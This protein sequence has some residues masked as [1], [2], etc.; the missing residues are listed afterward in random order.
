MTKT[1][2]YIYVR[3]FMKLAVGEAVLV[4]GATDF[5]NRGEELFNPRTM[6]VVLFRGGFCFCE[7][8]RSAGE[9]ICI[10]IFFLSSEMLNGTE[11][12]PRRSHNSNWT[13]AMGVSFLPFSKGF[14]EKL[15]LVSFHYKIKNDII[16]K[17]SLSQAEISPFFFPF[18]L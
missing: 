6:L 1:Y 16:K 2:I 7:Q 8:S 14:S 3:R 9:L 18:S 17:S 4:P 12:T 13:W 11:G 10:S 15:P 5:R